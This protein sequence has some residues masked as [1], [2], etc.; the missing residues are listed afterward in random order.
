M[1]SINALGEGVTSHLKKVP[2]AKKVHKNPQLRDQAGNQPAERSSASN[3]P[4]VCLIC[5]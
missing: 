3:K 2:D 4:Q 5:H 1:N